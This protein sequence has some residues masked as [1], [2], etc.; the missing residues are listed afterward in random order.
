MVVRV[1][2]PRETVKKEEDGGVEIRDGWDEMIQ[3]KWWWK[4]VAEGGRQG[5]L[6]VHTT[7]IIN[8]NT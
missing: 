8:T 4:T 7:T 5:A 3:G 2:L 1:G 6:S